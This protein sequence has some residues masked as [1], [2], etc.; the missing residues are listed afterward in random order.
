MLQVPIG[1]TTNSRHHGD[2]WERP[3]PE[4][5]RL[6]GNTDGIFL[7]A[8]SLRCCPCFNAAFVGH[9]NLDAVCYQ[10]VVK[11]RLRRPARSGCLLITSLK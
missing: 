5:C 8:T 3:L 9:N 7:F 1:G 6:R 11:P 2:D 4:G 10:F